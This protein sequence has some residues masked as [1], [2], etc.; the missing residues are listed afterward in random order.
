MWRTFSESNP[1][2]DVNVVDDDPSG[3]VN[4]E[5]MDV[6]EENEVINEIVNDN[7]S[8]YYVDEDHYL[9][10]SLGLPNVG[11]LELRVSRSAVGSER[12]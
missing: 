7:D 2:V 4:I 1:D 12:F 6:S 9:D 11:R 10:D 5:D 8:Y 3:N